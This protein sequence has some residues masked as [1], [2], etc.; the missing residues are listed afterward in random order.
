VVGWLRRV[1]L[2]PAPSFEE[3]WSAYGSLADTDTRRA[4]FHTLHS[5]VD[6]GGQ[7]P[8]ATNRLYLLAGM[9]TMILWGDRDPI[10]PVEHA[11]VAH[12]AIAGSVLHVFDGVGHFPQH[13]EPER[14][15]RVVRDFIGSSAPATLSE[16]HLRELL[17][18][19]LTA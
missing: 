4:F 7:R 12:E 10:I 13:D 6:S 5:V 19:S 9:P 11:H 1:G 15:V 3:I 14:F 8:S 2:R 16:A 18:G 17:S